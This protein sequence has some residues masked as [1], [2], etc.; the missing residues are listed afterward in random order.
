MDIIATTRKIKVQGTTCYLPALWVKDSD[1]KYTYV[2]RSDPLVFNAD[3]L[4]YAVIWRDECLD[5]GYIT[6]F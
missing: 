5:R 2:S 1:F 4:K 6:H 3:A